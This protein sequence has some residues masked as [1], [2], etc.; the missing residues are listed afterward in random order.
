MEQNARDAAWRRRD[1]PNMS[2]HMG[3]QES[4]HLDDDYSI[5]QHDDGQ[6]TQSTPTPI[7]DL[8]TDRI[9]DQFSITA[10]TLIVQCDNDHDMEQ[11]LQRFIR[12][13]RL[14]IDTLAT[15]DG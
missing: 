11:L 10:A 4:K 9:L 14:D 3:T 15:T 1:G 8:A 2:V 12:Q 5:L 13:L 6:D 7:T